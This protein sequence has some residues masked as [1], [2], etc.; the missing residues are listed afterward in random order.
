MNNG[1]DQ[2][3]ADKTS[4]L[5]SMG[6]NRIVSSILIV[7]LKLFISCPLQSSN[8]NFEKLELYI[9]IDTCIFVLDQKM[10]LTISSILMQGHL[11]VVKFHKAMT[12]GSNHHQSMHLQALQV[13]LHEQLCSSLQVKIKCDTNT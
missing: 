2:E 12:Y 9:P 7:M 11:G 13:N 3:V 5:Q 4:V 10:I 1:S 6:E 8:K